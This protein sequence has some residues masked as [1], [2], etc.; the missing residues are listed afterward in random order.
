MDSFVHHNDCDSRL[1][2]LVSVELP[3]SIFQLRDFTVQHLVALS[4]TDSISED[5]EVCWEV[6]AVVLLEHLNRI[7]AELSHFRLDDLLALAL[8][9]VVAEVLR[10]LFVG[11]SREANN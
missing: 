8:H 3:N 4:I 9:Q 11:G 10:H 1:I 2:S 7:F 5:D 6:S